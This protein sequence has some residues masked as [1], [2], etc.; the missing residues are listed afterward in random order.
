MRVKVS[1]EEVKNVILQ[2]FDR[3]FI[4]KFNGGS[5][6]SEK[7]LKGWMDKKWAKIL[8]YAPKTHMGSR[9]FVTFLFKS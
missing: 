3:D 9:G 8:G 7:A 5:N 1:E 2:Y 4:G 6:I